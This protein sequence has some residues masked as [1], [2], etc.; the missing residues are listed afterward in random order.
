M[1]PRAGRRAGALL[2]LALLVAGCAALVPQ[3]PSAI[4]DL[5][6]PGEAGGS[7]RGRLQILVPAPSAVQALDTNRIAARPSASEYAYLPGAVWSDTLPKLL[8]AR[9]VQT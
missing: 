9:L 7:G 2:M 1:T 4:Y 8:Q 3:T 5:S 6:A